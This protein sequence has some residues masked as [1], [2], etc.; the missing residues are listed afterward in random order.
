MRLRN[1]I[2]GEDGRNHANLWMFKAKTGRNQPSPAEFIFG[3]A[4]WVRC[5]IRSQPG[6]GVAY[7]DFE[8]QEFGIAAAFSGD[9]AMT[10]AYQSGDPYL[11]F[12]VQAGL[13]PAGGTKA[14]HKFERG[15]CK[16]CVLATQYGMG[17]DSLARRI[18]QERSIARDLLQ[19]HRNTYATFWKW[20][21]QKVDNAIL[22]QSIQT[23]L[24]W[25][26]YLGHEAKA[27]SVGNFPM[28]AN[29]AEMLRLACCY[30]TEA[31]IRVCA[32][33][34]DALLIEAPLS[35]LAEQVVQAQELMALASEHILQG[36]R[37]RTE[38]EVFPYPQRYQD[39]RGVKM[40]NTVWKVL[41]DP[42]YY[43]EP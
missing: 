4:T 17:V 12:G 24:G 11:A 25:G 36:F 7:I 6:W 31:G 1:L 2:V 10:H 21:Q 9:T 15:L 29:G 41:D 14:T 42:R 20:Y 28:Q 26:L 22:S 18:D 5:F 40:W 19:K 3:P 39:E 13:I 43:I 8:Q 27:T 30:L 38:A 32:P 33:V 16:Q 34:H 23:C 37:L 35:R